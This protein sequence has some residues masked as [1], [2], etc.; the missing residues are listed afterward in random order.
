MIVI[1]RASVANRVSSNINSG[2][3]RGIIM[4][5]CDFARLNMLGTN[6]INVEKQQKIQQMTTNLSLSH[7]LSL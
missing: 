3:A 7:T 6:K 4:W 2:I 1:I 5:T